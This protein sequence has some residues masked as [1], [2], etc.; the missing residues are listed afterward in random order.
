MRREQIAPAFAFV[1]ADDLGRPPDQD[2]TRDFGIVHNAPG[3]GIDAGTVSI[4]PAVR[5]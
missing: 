3:Y 4:A 5:P 2:A 1:Y